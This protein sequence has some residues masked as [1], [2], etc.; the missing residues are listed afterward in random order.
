M[1]KLGRRFLWF[2]KQRITR[3]AIIFIQS[4]KSVGVL[5]VW[6]G[7]EEEDRGLRDQLESG[8][9]SLPELPKEKLT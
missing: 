9:N 2:V 3:R 4:S 7:R 1:G 5:G 8:F 6:G